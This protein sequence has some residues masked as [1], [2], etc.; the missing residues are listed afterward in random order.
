MAN[1]NIDEKTLVR[2]AT[3]VQK[4]GLETLSEA[5]SYLLDIHDSPAQ[6][7]LAPYPV[8]SN[9]LEIVYSPLGEENFKRQLLE[10]KRAYIRMFY[11]DGKII[12]AIWNAQR[13]TETSSVRGNLASGYLRGWQK[14]GIY[15]VRVS[16]KPFEDKQGEER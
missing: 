4:S 12:N 5:I 9:S 16:I 6:T 8:L 14:E 3:Y 7:K 10:Y 1:I 15:K 11:K 13:F 2:L